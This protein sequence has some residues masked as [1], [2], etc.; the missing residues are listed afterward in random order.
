MSSSMK[1]LCDSILPSQALG[2]SLRRKPRGKENTVQG[3]SAQL[4]RCNSV[5]NTNMEF[6]EPTWPIM[7]DFVIEFMVF[8]VHMT[9]TT[10]LAMCRCFIFTT[11]VSVLVAGVMFIYFCCHLHQSDTLLLC[12]LVDAAYSSNLAVIVLLV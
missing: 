3:L 10:L 9:W 7:T 1:V 11:G 8:S 12:N 4:K 5:P 6:D 2:N